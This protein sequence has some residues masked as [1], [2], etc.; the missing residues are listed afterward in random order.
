MP[1]N[2]SGG[3]LVLVTC[4]SFPI[5]KWGEISDVTSKDQDQLQ[6]LL[7]HGL[8]GKFEE[9][10]V[11]VLK[12]PTT[13]EFKDLLVQLKKEV[14]SSGF[15][16]LYLATHVVKVVKGEKENPKELTKEFIKRFLHH[17]ENIHKSQMK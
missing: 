7:S 8:I 3:H 11:H 15:L 2:T 12:N 13:N 16:V 9:E 4:N 14:S 10:N 6:Y 17:K 1:I 5:G